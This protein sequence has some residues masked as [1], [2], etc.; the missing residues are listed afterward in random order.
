MASDLNKY[1][2]Y[3]GHEDQIDF[4]WLGNLQEFIYETLRPIIPDDDRR[5]QYVEEGPM[6]VWAAAFTHETAS[7]SFNYER[8]E[9]LGDRQLKFLFTEYLN[10]RYA[11]S[12]KG[13][14]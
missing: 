9:L 1:A 5:A 11:R 4:E 13:T 6:R 3:L 14:L 8:L 2:E 7:R 10:N 12:A